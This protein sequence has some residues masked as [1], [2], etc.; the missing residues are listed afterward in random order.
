M[1]KNVLLLMLVC[2][3]ASVKALPAK[4]NDQ[5]QSYLEE[6]TNAQEYR[7]M[8][9]M[10]G[11][12][13]SK[14]EFSFTDYIAR[15]LQGRE[16]ITG[17]KVLKGILA[18]LTGQVVERGKELTGL[19][20][21]IMLTAVFTGFSKAFRNGQVAESG[22]YVSYMLLF[23]MLASGYLGVSRL[24]SKT[25]GYVAEFMKVLVPVFQSCLVF[26]SGGLTS[27]TAATLLLLLLAVIDQV[28]VHVLLPMVHVY[29]MGVLVNHL[30]EEEPLSKLTEL[31]A[32]GIRF[33]LKTALGVITGISV[34][35]S[36]LTPMLDRVKRG[37]LQRIWEGIPGI[38]G[39]LG[40]VTETVLG[41]GGV[42]KN[43]VG[44]GGMIVIVLLCALPV[45]HVLLC[46]FC[47][48]ASAAIVE[49]VAD[50]RIVHCLSD[51]AEGVLMLCQTL[52]FG[53]VMLLLTL[54]IL[55][56]ATS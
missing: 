56:Y 44:T 1:K 20:G 40:G 42:I 2:F 18:A 43:A 45:L 47:Y 54:A 26:S 35:Q 32:K 8:E 34:L 15:V 3:V 30:S 13:F 9:Q 25:L 49:P 39:M 17:K 4:G 41:A 31:L 48:R 36:M 33:I 37:A 12:F 6:L 51:T 23:S 50:K 38:G 7:D 46:V 27:K 21:I 29:M 22:Y 19:I 10:V 11:E 24:V 28:L 5:M 52:L 16:A 53:A 14:D 55:I